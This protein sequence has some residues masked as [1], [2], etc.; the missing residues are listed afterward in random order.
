MLQS[1]RLAKGLAYRN[2]RFDF[3]VEICEDKDMKITALDVTMLKTIDGMHWTY[4]E[5]EERCRLRTLRRFGVVVTRD[6]QGVM[7]VDWSTVR[8]S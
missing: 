8:V 1:C 3:V 7:K 5:F 2:F 6:D 4:V